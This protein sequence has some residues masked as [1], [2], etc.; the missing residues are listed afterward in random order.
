MNISQQTKATGTW[1]DEAG[2]KIPYGILKKSEKENEKLIY[3]IAKEALNVSDRLKKLKI[4]IAAKIDAA[5]TNFHAD[6]S[7]KKKEFKGNY[8]FFNFDY[9][10]QV[11]VK[12]GRPVKLDDLMIG[13]AKALL[14]EFLKDGVTT[15]TTAIKEMIM[16]AFETSRGKMD[17]KKILGLRRY[18][19][20]I[21]DKRFADAMALID[22]A[23]RRPTTCTYYQVAVR[24]EQGKYDAVKLS[25]SDI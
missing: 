14:D 24:N 16:D 4:F 7:G 18:A 6:Y 21:E 25:L 20:R 22:R 9:S 15:K 12:V 23:I 3:S 11:K 1:M 2:N 19:D 17:T 10:I 8:T 5:V 13:E